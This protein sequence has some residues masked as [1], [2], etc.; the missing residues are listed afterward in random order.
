MIKN[1]FDNIKKSEFAGNFKILSSGIL[2]SQLIMIS[3]TPVITRLYSPSEF[4][5]YALF[6]AILGIIIPVACGRYDIATVV[7]KEDTDGDKLFF[8]SLI[9]GLIVSIIL[10]LVFFFLES[11][12]RE[13]LDA[14]KLDYWWYVLPGAIFLQ[15]IFT[16]LKSYANRYK[17][18]SIISRGQITFALSQVILLTLLG[19]MGFSSFGL[20]ASYIT[21]SVIVLIILC[22]FYKNFFLKSRWP[23]FK[24]LLIIAKRHIK[25]PFIQGT[26]TLFNMV[27]FML[28]VIFLTKY[29]PDIFV[30]YYALVMKVI[31][32][33]LTFFSNSISMLNM[34]K[35]A[36]IVHKK[37]N[38]T[39][40]LIKIT[41]IVFIII[42]FPSIIVIKYGPDIFSFVF[43]SKWIMAGEFASIL[44]PGLFCMFIASTLGQVFAATGRLYISGFWYVSFFIV[45]LFFFVIF[46]KDLEINQVLYFLSFLN[47]IFYTIFYILICYVIYRPKKI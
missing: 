33:P 47:I 3:S 2:I 24:K 15:S 6:T 26:S 20:F 45:Q 17:C 34:K 1:F 44:M 16:N 13:I 7:V 5:I 40:Y 36:E 18:Y 21:S 22:L 9:V 41:F 38:P 29:F 37:I 43:G 42:F 11:P 10:F 30:G 39:N 23:G 32:F 28:P 35:I 14:D 12:L 19:L 27:R 8:L 25:F 4:G 46:A 31:F